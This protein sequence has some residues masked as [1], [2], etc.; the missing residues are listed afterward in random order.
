MLMGMNNQNSKLINKANILKIVTMQGPVSRLDLH[1]ITELSK[2]TIS[3]L[4]SEYIE[5]GIMRIYE[6]G[7]QKVGR[8]TEMLEGGTSGDDRLRRLRPGGGDRIVAK[9]AS[10]DGPEKMHLMPEM[11]AAV[12]GYLRSDRRGCEGAR[13]QPVFLQ[14]LRSVCRSLSS[15]RHIDASR[16]GFRGRP[17]GRV[18]RRSGKCG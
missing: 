12:S 16:V 18:R 5:D 11:L 1:R 3:N 2:M 13:D 10:G 17:L 4:V 9:H 15:E 8:K 14:G 7:A 6:S